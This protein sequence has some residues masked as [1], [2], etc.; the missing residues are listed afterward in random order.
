VCHNATL[1]LAPSQRAHLTAGRL[2][3]WQRAHSSIHM[4][5]LAH[6]LTHI[7]TLH[8][9]SLTLTHFYTHTHLHT[10]LHAH[11]LTH[12]YTYTHTHHATTLTPTGRPLLVYFYPSHTWPVV[13][14]KNRHTPCTFVLWYS[15]GS[16]ILS[17][18]PPCAA[19]LLCSP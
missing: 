12:T 13:S 17:F 2:A 1:L 6:S 14:C 18:L 10:L 3:G 16:T 11:T 4:S 5:P 7:I 19:A 8:T 15:I 9:H